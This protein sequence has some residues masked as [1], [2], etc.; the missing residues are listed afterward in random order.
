MFISIFIRDSALATFTD[1]HYYGPTLL[2]HVPMWKYRQRPLHIATNMK[3][4]SGS[5][6]WESWCWESVH[7]IKWIGSIRPIHTKRWRYWK[8]V[9]P[10]PERSQRFAQALEMFYL[11]GFTK[12]I[13][14][15]VGS[16]WLLSSTQYAD[17]DRK[18]Q[19][20]CALQYRSQWIQA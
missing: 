5:V 12:T 3:M 15:V 14:H 2:A 10:I 19:S 6:H 16:G 13:L 8:L 4:T 18:S 7:K 9:P 17:Q 1:S 11:F 20:I